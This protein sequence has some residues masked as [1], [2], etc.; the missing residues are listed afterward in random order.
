MLAVS[1]VR[2]VRFR[3]PVQRLAIGEDVRFGQLVE[4]VDEQLNDE[5]HQEDGGDLEES[6]EVHAMPVAGP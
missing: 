2:P 1:A 3:G 6:R 5:H 4:P